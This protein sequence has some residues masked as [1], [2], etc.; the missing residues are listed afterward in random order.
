[1]SQACPMCG[2]GSSAVIGELARADLKKIWIRDLGI[3]PTPW[4]ATQTLEYQQCGRCDLRYFDD[5]LAGPEEMYR[6]LD[7]LS[8]YYLE[9]KP[10]FAVAMDKL[11]GAE[12]VLEIGAG[13]GAFG[14]QVSRQATYVGLELEFLGGRES[15]TGRPRCSLRA[16]RCP[17]RIGPSRLRCGRQLPGHGACPGRRSLHRGVPTQLAAG[18]PAHCV[19]A[20]PRRFHG[21]RAQ[22]YP[23]PATPSPHPVVGSVPHRSRVLVRPH[24]D[25]S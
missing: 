13:A 10:E 3:D 7:K 6:K 12:R 5:D 1:M 17:S 15:G 25:R 9:D 21:E 23:G 8:W 16:L 2:S 19:G 22:Q 18:W 20:V 11:N 4:I 24:I 14:R